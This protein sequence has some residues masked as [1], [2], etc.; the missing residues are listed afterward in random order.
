MKLNVLHT[1][2]FKYYYRFLL[3]VLIASSLVSCQKS[4][5]KKIDSNNN[6]QQFITQKD[7]F[8]FV[9]NT[10]AKLYGSLNKAPFD[11]LDFNKVIAYEFQGNP[12]RYS[13]IENE[14]FV[15]L[16]PVIYK[17]ERLN[18]RQVISLINL[19][20]SKQTY[21]GQYSA[22]FEPHQ[23]FGFFKDTEIKYVIDMCMDCNR[24]E[25]SGIFPV[26]IPY[27]NNVP[28]LGFSDTGRSKIIELSKQL[29]LRYANADPH[30]KSFSEE[31]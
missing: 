18:E 23:A 26:K 27:K 20:T 15:F 3:F 12:E 7:L 11:T 1:F 24:L 31:E 9:K 17:Q 13:S 22:C 6:K 8:Q 28:L 30:Y 19:L 16:S 2:S 5:E 21:G 14:S 10:E 29:G 25:T 4:A